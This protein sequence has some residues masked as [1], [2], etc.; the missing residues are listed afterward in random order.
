MQPIALVVMAVAQEDVR[1][2]VQVAVQLLVLAR[3]VVVVVEVAQELL[4]N[5]SINKK[6]I[7]YE[8]EK[9]K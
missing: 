6:K 9:N 5:H 1:V 4:P 7:C 2:A 3:A 8:T